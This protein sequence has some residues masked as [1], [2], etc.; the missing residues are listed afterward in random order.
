MHLFKN[1]KNEKKKRE[2]LQA[3]HKMNQK[4][5]VS[6]EATFICRHCYIC[7]EVTFFETLGMSS[8][9]KAIMYKGAGWGKSRH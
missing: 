8:L 4:L 3:T 2:V 5:T 7:D 1:Q 9:K 6:I